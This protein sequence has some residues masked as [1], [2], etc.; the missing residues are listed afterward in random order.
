MLP[1]LREVSPHVPAIEVSGLL[2]HVADIK[3]SI[4]GGPRGVF[5]E[6]GFLTK[7]PDLL[8]FEQDGIT[9]HFVVIDPLLGVPSNAPI[10]TI[11]KFCTQ[12]FP[13]ENKT[14]IDVPVQVYAE[15]N[16]DIEKT[17]AMLEAAIDRNDNSEEIIALCKHLLV[18]GYDLACRFIDCV[19]RKFSQYWLVYPTDILRWMTVRYFSKPRSAW[20]VIN[21]RE[22]FYP[23]NLEKT[24]SR[25]PSD[26]WQPHILLRGIDEQC[27]LRPEEL[28]KTDRYSFS[29]EMTATALVELK[30]GRKRS[31]ILH[32]VIGIESAAT[33][34]LEKMLADRLSGLETGSVLQSISKELSVPALAQMVHLHAGSTQRIDWNKINSLY[35]IRN[36]IVHCERKRLPDFDRM[37]EL[38]LE[39][40]NY[41]SIIQQSLFVGRSRADP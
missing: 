5:V 40:F 32:A 6:S 3:E 2:F 21:S 17:Q 29:E 38:L 18:A 7:N 22:D 41:V 34:G 30:S 20:Y 12:D 37:K 24:R 31:A 1:P 28:D 19:R 10:T 16:R 33:R 35:N 9:F 36:E 25:N 15:L 14:G 8:Q 39:A 27:F 4:D 13:N 23:D 26:G 11:H